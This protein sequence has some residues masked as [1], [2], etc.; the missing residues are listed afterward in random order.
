MEHWKRNNPSL[1]VRDS[2]EDMIVMS[3]DEEVEALPSSG[4]SYQA[5]PLAERIGPVVTGQQ[6]VCSSLGYREAREQRRQEKLKAR[7]L[8]PIKGTCAARKRATTFA[9]EQITERE[10]QYKEAL[11]FL[12][13]REEHLAVELGAY[14]EDSKKENRDVG[15]GPC[16]GFLHLI[17]SP[18]PSPIPILPPRKKP[19]LKKV[20]EH[21]HQLFE[22][23][24]QKFLHGEGVPWLEWELERYSPEPH[25]ERSGISYVSVSDVDEFLDSV[26]GKL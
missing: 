10:R 1:R 26:I 21:L 5:P 4:G 8:E 9:A 2:K 7:E 13:S 17:P 25:V 18:S 15:E 22:K 11:P 6:T 24:R 20:T 19:S 3:D 14:E 23:D 16:H 12:S